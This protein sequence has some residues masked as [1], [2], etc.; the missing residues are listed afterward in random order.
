MFPLSQW[1]LFWLISPVREGQISV[2]GE[3]LDSVNR[4][5]TYGIHAAMQCGCSVPA[6][7]WLESSA[8][9]FVHLVAHTKRVSPFS[10]VKGGYA[11]FQN[12]FGRTCSN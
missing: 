11:L 4:N 9:G 10:A 5:V 1:K 8:V 2:W 7:E 3:E 12:D 6:A